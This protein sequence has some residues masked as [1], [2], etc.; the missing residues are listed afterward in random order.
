MKTIFFEI[1]FRKINV[2]WQKSIFQPHFLMVGEF[3]EK[4]L[5][6]FPSPCCLS[7]WPGDEIRNGKNINQNDVPTDDPV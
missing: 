1:G 6:R 3:G 5:Q 7:H 2:Q 4:K